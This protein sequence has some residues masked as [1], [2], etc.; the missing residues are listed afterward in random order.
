MLIEALVLESNSVILRNAL[1]CICI[2]QAVIGICLE[3]IIM[4]TYVDMKECLL[5]FMIA[6]KRET[7]GMYS[8]RGLVSDISLETQ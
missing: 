4:E 8:S 7:N 6:R 3:H 5:F 2:C 1:I